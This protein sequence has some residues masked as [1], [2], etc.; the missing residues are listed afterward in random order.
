MEILESA[1]MAEKNPKEV[2]ELKASERMVRDLKSERIQILLSVEWTETIL[3][4]FSLCELQDK[5]ST[6]FHSFLERF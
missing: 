5:E 4:Y 3:Q 1:E 2:Q 6:I